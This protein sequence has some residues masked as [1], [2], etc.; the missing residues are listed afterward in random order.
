MSA[1]LR[2]ASLNH[3]NDDDNEDEDMFATVLVIILL[4]ILEGRATRI[5]RRNANRLYLRR[6]DLL[7]NPRTGTPW[8][9]L[10]SGQNDRAFITTMGF[11]VATFR[12]ILEGPGHFADRWEVSTIPRR[13][14]AS[15]GEPRLG[16]RSL[17][18][19][20]G[21]G[22]VLHFLGS[23]MLDTSLQQI[24]ALTPATV[25]RYL[26]FS[27]TILLETVRGMEEAA[28]RLPRSLLEFAAESQLVCERHPLLEGAFGA[29]DGLALAAQEADDPEVEN[30][31]YNGWQSTHTI[32]NVLV[33]SPRG[34]RTTYTHSLSN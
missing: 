13:D 31:T 9:V 22:L 7:P 18:A 12:H 25:S 32:N 1:A 28:I 33:F 23:A 2:F 4:H 17:D 29:I 27:K 21:L 34:K 14:V 26:G 10:W 5:Q 6:Q 19:A 3:L 15:V 24:F 30:A 11:N 8:Q 16:S 20:G